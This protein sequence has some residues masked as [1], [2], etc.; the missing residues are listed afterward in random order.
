[1][2]AKYKEMKGRLKTFTVLYLW[3]GNLFRL[4]EYFHIKLDVEEIETERWK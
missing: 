2:E 1:M 4:H 3:V